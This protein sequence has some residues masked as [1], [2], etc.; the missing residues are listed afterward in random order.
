MTRESKSNGEQKLVQFLMVQ[1]LLSKRVQQLTFDGAKPGPT[2][3]CFL[4]LPGEIR[5]RIYEQVVLASCMIHEISNAK[6]WCRGLPIMAMVSKTVREELLSLYF[7]E[8][9]LQLKKN[10]IFG[11]AHQDCETKRLIYPPMARFH[12]N[13]RRINVLGSVYGYY[14]EV[15]LCLTLSR[16]GHDFELIA[17]GVAQL[18]CLFAGFVKEAAE[19]YPEEHQGPW[20][21]SQLLDLLEYIG[22]EAWKESQGGT[23]SVK[24]TWCSDLHVQSNQILLCSRRW[25]DGGV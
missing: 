2:V 20:D 25:V 13:L 4:D 18:S 21:G 16:N 10:E 12:I 17:H 9:V 15:R 6:H 1:I 3:R 23:R 5:N 22:E 7:T 14:G 24:N 8:V 19:Q 11:R